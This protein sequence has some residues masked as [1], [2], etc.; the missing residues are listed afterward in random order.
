MV[1]GTMIVYDNKRTVVKT[2][3]GN[4]EELKM[5]LEVFQ[6]PVLGSPLLFVDVVEALTCEVG[7]TSHGRYDL[8]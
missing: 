8:V 6:G 3:H 7:R 5:K 4:I 2:K 1:I